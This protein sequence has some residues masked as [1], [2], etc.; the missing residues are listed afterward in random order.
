RAQLRRLRRRRLAARSPPGS[1]SPPHRS[2]VPAPVYRPRHSRLTAT[3]AQECTCPSALHADTSTVPASRRAA[4]LKRR[5]TGRRPSPDAY[6]VSVTS[7]RDRV[8]NAK[9]RDIEAIAWGCHALSSGGRSCVPISW[10]RL[11]T[12]SPPAVRVRHLIGSLASDTPNPAERA[13]EY[14]LESLGRRS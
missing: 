6:R 12:L 4:K 11:N 13:R 3:L 10:A 5:T 9:R 8:C 2:A 1:S 14:V 7:P